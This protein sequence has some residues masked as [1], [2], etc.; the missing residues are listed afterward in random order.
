MTE[1]ETT[2]KPSTPARFSLTR[3][4]ILSLLSAPVVGA[5]LW[6][7]TDEVLWGVVAGATF[8][9]AMIATFTVYRHVLRRNPRRA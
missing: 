3:V 8:A 5:I 9:A 4:W 6:L 7:Q 1:N 2:P